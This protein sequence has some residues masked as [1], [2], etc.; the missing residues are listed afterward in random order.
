MC[1]LPVEVSAP[2]PGSPAFQR[3]LLSGR[4]VPSIQLYFGFVPPVYR[5]PTKMPKTIQFIGQQQ[6]A[7]LQSE[8]FLIR[9]IRLRI[10]PHTPTLT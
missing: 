6:K 8:K 2:V 10:S 7:N 4:G 5:T 3:G 1:P 9:E